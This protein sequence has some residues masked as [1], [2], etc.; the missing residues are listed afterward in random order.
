[1]YTGLKL[2]STPAWSIALVVK[3][4]FFLTIHQICLVPTEGPINEGGGL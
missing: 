1:M 2:C 4:P 3:M